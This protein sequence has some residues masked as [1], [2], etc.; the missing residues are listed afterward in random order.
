MRTSPVPFV[1]V[2]TTL[3]DSP[4]AFM[5][6]RMRARRS[7]GGVSMN[8][9]LR[10]TPLAGHFRAT[11]TAMRR[12]PPRRPMG[13]RTTLRRSAA[14]SGLT[15]TARLAAAASLSSGRLLGRQTMRA[16]DVP[17]YSFERALAMTAV[18]AVKPRP[19]GC[20]SLA[21]SRL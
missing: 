18:T 16:M 3:A 11:T 4:Q 7:R 2:K 8:E 20:S 6:R 19:V 9:T 5:C 21:Q 14:L 17:R 1:S 15:S 10:R 13:V 12:G